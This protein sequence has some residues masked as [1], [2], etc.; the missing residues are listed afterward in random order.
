MAHER[1]IPVQELEIRSAGKAHRLE[2]YAAVFNADSAPLPYIET[3]APGAFARSLTSP[4]NGRQTL[5]VDHDDSRLL[6]ATNGAS[7]LRLSEDAHGLLVSGDIADTSYARDLR[8][9]SDGGLLGG[10]SFEFSAT[11]GGA[12]FTSDGKR[13]TLREVRLY[14]VTVLT[15]K[16]PAYG[17][18]TASVRA[19]ANQVQA[20]FDDVTVLLDAVREGRRLDNDEWSLLTR[21]ATHVAPTDARWSSA[22]ADAA[23]ASYVLASLLSLLG[24]EADDPAQAAHLNTAI[25][26]V[27]AFIAAESG[28][29]GT[30][31]DIA[32]SG[33]MDA[34]RARPR[35]A[36]ARLLFP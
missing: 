32:D 15:G 21:I 30:P 14:H 3:V 20:D 8:E 1:S 9:L 17:V 23:D 22:A 35:L 27:Q 19:L 36:E 25:A 18:T 33:G 31:E 10:M 5:V 34:M 2:G 13:R 11:K 26:E 4:P 28:E 24:D 29:I 16:T 6:A 12:P 7:P